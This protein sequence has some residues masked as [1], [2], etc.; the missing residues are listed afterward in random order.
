MAD[1]KKVGTLGKRD[2]REDKEELSSWRIYPK[3][4][5]SGGHLC[6]HVAQGSTGASRP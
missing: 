5:D 6:K 1:L 2:K 4:H 3:Q